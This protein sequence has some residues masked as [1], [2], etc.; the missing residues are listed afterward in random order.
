MASDLKHKKSASTIG[1]P[2]VKTSLFTDND[3]FKGDG[4]S[5]ENCKGIFL[6]WLSQAERWRI[7]P[8]FSRGSF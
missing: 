8:D 4:E 2:G 1:Q 6:E 3:T 7:R 5:Q